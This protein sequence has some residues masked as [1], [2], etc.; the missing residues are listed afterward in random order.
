MSVHITDLIREA[1][2]GNKPP[3]GTLT[4]WADTVG[5]STATVSRWRGGTVPDP[6]NWAGLADALEMTVEEIETACGQTAITFT[7][8][9]V[10]LDRLI[11]LVEQLSGKG[12]AQRQNRNERDSTPA[13]MPRPVLH[14]RRS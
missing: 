4:R 7:T 3:R 2:G 11:A 8:I 14:S 9:D 1:T 12:S 6:E 13:E 10:K 5:V